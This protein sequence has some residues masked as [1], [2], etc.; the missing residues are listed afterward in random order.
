MTEQSKIKIVAPEGET[1]VYWALPGKTV[2]QVL[3]MAGLESGG[4]CGGQK[5]CGKCKVRVEGGVSPLE[6]N[7]QRL[8]MPEEIKSGLRLACHCIISSDAVI[9]LDLV[10]ADYCVK[11]RLSQYKPAQHLRSGVEYKSFFIPGQLAEK[12]L[13]LFDRIQAAL[14]EYKFELTPGN[15][16]QLHKL[17]RP[18]RP[19]LEL[20]ALICGQTIYHVQRENKPALGV[21]LDL[22]TT[23]LFA[24]LLDLEKG[25][26]LA[27]VSQSNMQRIYGQDMVS[28]LAYAQEQTDG[29]V[30]LHKIMINN[31][32]AM[33]D[34]MIGSSGQS[35]DDIYKLC[36]VGN[37][38]MLHFFLGLTTEGFNAAPFSGLFS[39]SLEISAAQ[40]ELNVNPRARLLI[41]PQ[42]G[43]FVGA[44]MTACLLTMQEGF[45]KTFLLCDIGTNSEIALYNQGE[46]WTSSAAAGPALEGGALNCGMRAAAGAIERFKITQE[47]LQYQV[48]GKAAPKGICGSGVIDLLAELLANDYINQEGTF[49]PQAG[50]YFT[51]RE[52]NQGQE[53]VLLD[54][55]ETATN[56]PLIFT[57]ED[58]RQIQLAKGAIRTAIDILLE[59]ARLKPAELENIYIAGA[60][61]SYLDAENLIKIGLLPPVKR[62]KIRNIGNAAAEGAIITLLSD[63]AMAEADQIKKKVH[64]VELANQPDFQ[65]RFLHN[66]NFDSTART[67]GI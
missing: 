31:I 2:Q 16:N 50:D 9:Y 13:P 18:G 37:P 64:H 43:G 20:H 32:N 56:T 23:S 66:L 61:G 53:I 44:D 45:N 15:L 60:F 52:G 24:A 14:P 25:E 42:L 65:E 38:V 62:E 36:A 63:T 28:R 7:E 55:V 54:Q 34:D 48:I 1:S 12:A 41:P 58:V 4:S 6:E 10:A 22:G 30:S 57:Q 67:H 17:D 51:C 21:A 33:I 11:S 8:L 19:A 5:T 29:A 49:T 46:I 47:E 39:T 26:V 3:E 40:L 27:T 35:A 59:K